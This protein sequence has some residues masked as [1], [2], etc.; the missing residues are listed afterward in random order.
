MKKLVVLLLVSLMATAAFAQ[1]DPDA[2][3]VGVYFDTGAMTNS[4]VIAPAAA[5][6]CYII[7]TNPSS[8]LVQGLEVG[9]NIVAPPGSWFRLQNGL[10]TGA[11]DLGNSDDINV[12]DYVVGLADPIPSTSAVVFVTWQIFQ[13]VPFAQDRK[14]VV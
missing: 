9:Y 13:T 4:A 5:T 3:M 2:D 12:G 8:P 6:P 11:V 7:I 1:I 10:P 14:S